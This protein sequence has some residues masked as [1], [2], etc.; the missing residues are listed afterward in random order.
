MKCRTQNEYGRM[1]ETVMMI[2]C[3]FFQNPKQEK[4]VKI[5]IVR[6][7]LMVQSKSRSLDELQEH[8]EI[9]IGMRCEKQM[10][11]SVL[12]YFQSDERK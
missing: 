5:E 10:F 11:D 7:M 1:F 3:F 12:S 8:L 9:L 6:Q 2:W 4:K